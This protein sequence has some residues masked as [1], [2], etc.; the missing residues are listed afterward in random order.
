V[1]L[2][3]LGKLEL[4]EG[5]GEFAVTEAESGEAA[6]GLAARRCGTGAGRGCSP[7]GA[8]G[9]AALGSACARAGAD[10]GLFAASST[11]LAGTS[12]KP[13]PLPICLNTQ[14]PVGLSRSPPSFSTSSPTIRKRRSLAFSFLL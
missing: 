5:S 9:V 2:R 3:D 10:E 4:S 13:K 11:L 8:S 1:D 12:P 7:G 14:L 6:I